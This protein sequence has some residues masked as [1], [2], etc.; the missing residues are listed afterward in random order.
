V[1]VESAGRLEV[2]RGP[3]SSTFGDTALGGVVQLFREPRT[4][5][6]VAI[7]T[8][9]MLRAQAT[10]ATERWHGTLSMTTTGG[11]RDHGSGREINGSG[12]WRASRLAVDV[13]LMHRRRDDPGPR[14]EEELRRDPFGSDPMFRF[15]G[16][17]T[18]R[19]RVSVRAGELIAQAHRRESETVRTLLLAPGF[20]DRAERLLDAWGA[21]I[22]AA[23]EWSIGKGRVLGGG[24]VSWDALDTRY[25]DTSARARG[26]RLN[27]AAFL[28]GEWRATT[29]LRIAA[30]ARWDRIEDEFAVQQID[31]AFSPRIGLA[32]SAG[33]G[34]TLWLAVSR[35]FKAPT[36]EQRF[37]PRPFPDFAGGT[38]TISNGALRPQNALSFEV[39][40]RGRGWDVVAYEMRVDDEI[41]FDVAT[42]R[43]AN[44]GRSM[45]RGLE[46]SWRRPPS[47]RL[48]P[49]LTYSW[50][51]VEPLEGE[52]RR[53]QLKN[54]ARHLLRGDL[55]I[56]SALTVSLEHAR[57]RYLD[58]ANEF[59]LHD[60]T[61]VDVALSRA[62]GSATAALHVRNFF[63]ERYAPLGFS[64]GEPF[65]FPGPGRSITATISWRP[66]TG[67]SS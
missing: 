25:A 17:E 63:D 10:G 46:V 23:H 60:T 57:G 61:I 43:Y 62:I 21:G 65:Y 52:H 34:S 50:T 41:D 31:D 53:N 38:F 29:R 15:D 18:R 44:I 40:T 54:I 67:G 58:D 45:H 8:F 30:G 47:R 27:T 33:G 64:L 28:S 7:G 49:M 11:F 26:H 51:R 3:G 22:G 42:F 32:Y 4:N 16:D 9:D 14:S 56:A 2:V 20:G 13:D 5:V 24:D 37:D 59:P 6:S 19:A 35:A 1:P 66:A 55:R 12:G 36:L 39:G 48:R